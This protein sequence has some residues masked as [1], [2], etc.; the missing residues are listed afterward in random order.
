MK[1]YSS[2]YNSF[3]LKRQNL[4]ELGKSYW[5]S[6]FIQA[7]Q[8][9]PC[10]Q[11]PNQL[12]LRDFLYEP[13]ARIPRY[14]MLLKEMLKYTSP[15]SA[16][17]TKLEEA[18]AAVE[19]VVFEMNQGVSDFEMRLQVR[20]ASEIWGTSFDFSSRIL[21][22]EGTLSKTDRNG[23]EEKLEI[24]LFNDLLVYG[25]R[26]FLGK[27]HLRFKT[28]LHSCSVIADNMVYT[29]D[30]VKSLVDMPP[31][32]MSPNQIKAAAEES[33]LDVDTVKDEEELKI[34]L[35]VEKEFKSTG[36]RVQWY[37]QETKERVQ[38]HEASNGL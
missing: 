18:Q 17:F 19:A 30:E 37:W 33:N 7:V 6:V 5:F 36:T 3:E 13:I 28:H 23:R 27:R 1:M 16:D 35:E 2:Y 15:G 11:R 24:L 34:W 14:N 8:R 32:M 10:C 20:K 12:L 38:R 21:V 22:K 9:Q 26:D 4:D 31:M 29:V 25:D